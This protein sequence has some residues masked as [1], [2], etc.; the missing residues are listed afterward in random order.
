MLQSRISKSFENGLFASLA[1]T[2]SDSRSVNDG[3]SI[4]QSQWRDRVVS[5]DPNE[6]VASYSS[7][8]QS[9]RFNAYGSYKL[10][11]LNEK[12]S[13]TFGFTYSVAPVA[14]AF[15]NGYTWTVP[16]GGTVVSG[17]GTTTLTVN[18]DDPAK[19]ATTIAKPVFIYCRAKKI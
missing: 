10:N 13:T 17:Q 15:A 9:H 4:A 8:M 12:A 18:F 3:G 7:Y 16:T 5:G 6:N 14:G 2:N 11:Y 1:Y 19:F